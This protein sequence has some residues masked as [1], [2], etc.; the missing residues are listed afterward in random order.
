MACTAT[1][2]LGQEGIP[3]ARVWGPVGAQRSALAT[4]RSYDRWCRGQGGRVFKGAC[5]A[6]SPHGC[7]SNVSVRCAVLLCMWLE[8]WAV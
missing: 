4:K 8:S 2:A 1:D 6:L 3:R 7:V 5:A